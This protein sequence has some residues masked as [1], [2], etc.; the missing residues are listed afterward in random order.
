MI[1]T[2]FGNN[3][4]ILWDTVDAQIHT[5]LYMYIGQRLGVPRKAIEVHC[6]PV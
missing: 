2:D 6:V 5:Y 1:S 4:N 3:G